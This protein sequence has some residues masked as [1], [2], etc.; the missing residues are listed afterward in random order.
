[1]LY[2]YL[3]NVKAFKAVVKFPVPPENNSKKVIT[4]GVLAATCNTW[5]V[6]K[7]SVPCIC[8][9]PIGLLSNAPYKQSAPQEG[10]DVDIPNI[11]EFNNAVPTTHSSLNCALNENVPAIGKENVHNIV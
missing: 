9:E 10:E 1:M 2:V 4:I 11:T 3:K 6:V 7:Q 5:W 8:A